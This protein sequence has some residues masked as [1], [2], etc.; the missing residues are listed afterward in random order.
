[1]KGTT[2]AGPNGQA[3]LWS[4]VDAMSI[5][6]DTPVYSA[7]KNYCSLSGSAKLMVEVDKY[8]SIY[9]DIDYAGLRTASLSFLQEAAGKTRVIAISDF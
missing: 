8:I 6:L 2:K 9:K 7:L 3:T 1:M 5:A 4:H